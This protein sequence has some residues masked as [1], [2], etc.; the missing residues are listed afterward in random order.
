MTEVILESYTFTPTTATAHLWLCRTG[1][2]CRPDLELDIEARFFE[3]GGG[4]VVKARYHRWGNPVELD[5]D[6]AGELIEALIHRRDE[7]RREYVVA[8][9]AHERGL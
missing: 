4:E 5:D 7:D 9:Y 3:Q 2:D 8:M 1:C 6:D